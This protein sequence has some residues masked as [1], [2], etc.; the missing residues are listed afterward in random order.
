MK[1]DFDDWAGSSTGKLVLIA[2]G[3]TSLAASGQAILAAAR[4]LRGEF[5]LVVAVRDRLKLMIMIFDSAVDPKVP[6]V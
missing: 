4:L 3:S 2:L 1:M 6:V 5:R